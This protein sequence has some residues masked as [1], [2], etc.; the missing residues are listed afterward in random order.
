[1]HILVASGAFKHS[2]SAAQA[3]DAIIQ[4][5]KE[6]LP[7]ATFTPLPIADGG[8][9]TLD[10]WLASGGTRHTVQVHDPLMRPIQADYGIL[11]DGETAIIEM[12]LASGIELLGNIELNPL[13]A[14]TYGTGELMQAALEQGATRFIVGM[15]GSATVDGG[16][17][18]LR[19]LGVQ[20]LDENGDEI[21][22]G[23]HL[24]KLHTID[25]SNLDARWHNCDIII[26]SDVDNPLLGEHGAAAVFAPQKG[27]TPND[28]ATLEENLRHFAD[29]IEQQYGTRIHDLEGAGAAG[30][31]SAG[32]MAFLPCKLVS[33]I[34]LLLD[35]NNFVAHLTSVNL[36]I[37]GEGQ[38][39]DQT[40]HGK[41]P[42]GVAKLAR[43][44]GVP[45]IAFVGGLNVHD[46]LLHKAGIQA[47]FPIV[48]KPMA[49]TNAIENAGA[50]L[51]RAA[52]RVG[53][54]LQLTDAS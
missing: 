23:D 52:L 7:S 17:G 42:L 54:V 43:E 31:L 44:Y 12:A 21:S 10:A 18:A 19:A 53:Y 41:G 24:T 14:T 33:G 25:T 34:D 13:K 48:D 49:L 4:G 27:A 39:D 15:G 5:L 36:V 51:T 1:M 29:V 50:L 28:V 32:L 11:V 2:L 46:S 35:Y 38:M 37:T 30:G 3:T 22:H 47:V 16:S 9:G 20:L 6:A 26:A 45:T 40:I 8:N